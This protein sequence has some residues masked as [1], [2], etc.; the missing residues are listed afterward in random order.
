MR[1]GTTT[2]YPIA[3]FSALVLITLFAGLSGGCATAPRRSPQ[4][5]NKWLTIPVK[6]LDATGSVLPPDE[7]PNDLVLTLGPIPG[8]VPGIGHETLQ[9][10]PIG[11]EKLI[12]I[13]IASYSAAMMSRVR[14]LDRSMSQ[15]LHVVPEDTQFVRAST[16]VWFTSPTPVRKSTGF[17]DLETQDNLVLV[18]FDRPCRLTGTVTNAVPNTETSTTDYDVVVE[19]PGLTW[20]RLQ[21]VGPMHTLG[22]RED[23]PHPAVIIVPPE[24]RLH[25]R[26]RIKPE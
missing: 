8:S 3:A 14:P 26:Y 7:T 20:I 19:S 15:S 1:A 11:H 23:H 9:T 21:P 12:S 5:A 13:D 10:V 6:V 16:G 25:G 17:I 24:N 18:Y 22:K 4:P 2:A